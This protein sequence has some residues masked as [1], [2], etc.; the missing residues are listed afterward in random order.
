MTTPQNELYR[1]S[2]KVKRLTDMFEDYDEERTLF[3]DV[4]QLYNDRESITKRLDRMEDQ[5]ALIIKL[6]TIE[7][8]LK[9]LPQLICQ[10]YDPD[11]L[12]RPLPDC[13]KKTG[14]THE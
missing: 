7:N 4:K 8:N 9:A 2:D 11:L 13:I 5:M 6:L 1:L 14:P 3:D 12:S 10:N